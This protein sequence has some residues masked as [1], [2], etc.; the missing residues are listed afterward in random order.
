MGTLG[1]RWREGR[2]C[3]LLRLVSLNP[4][5]GCICS[6]GPRRRRQTPD[7]T[8][9]SEATWKLDKPKLGEM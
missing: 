3:P 2:W 4:E 6:V 5:G 1:G 9:Y 8:R 7:H